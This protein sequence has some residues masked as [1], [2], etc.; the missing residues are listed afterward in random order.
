MESTCLRQTEVP[1]T[2]RLFADL[3]YNFDRVSDLYPHRPNS[4]EAVAQAAAFEFP[5]ARRAA[6]VSALAPLNPGNPSLDLLARPGT[7]AIITG[8]QVG[9]FSGPVYTIYKALTAIQTARQLSELGTPAV[10]VFWMA[11]EDHDFAEVNHVHVFGAD[12]QPVTLRV[13]ARLPGNDSTGTRPVGGIVPGDMPIAELRAALHGLPF[14]DETVALVER[15]CQGELTM[16]SAFARL[17][18]EIFRPFHLLFV[19]PM[20]PALREIAAPLMREAVERMPELADS[21]IARSKQLVDRGYH[22]QVLVDAQTSLAF[23]LENGHRYALRRT[24]G[25]FTAGSHKF[26]A[27]DLAA[28]AHQLSPNALLRPVLQDYMFPTAAYV[29]GPAELAYF[30]QSEV[31]YRNLLGRQPVAMPRAGF[32]I[33]DEKSAKHMRRYGLAAA[34]VFADERT[35]GDAIGRRLVPQQLKRSLENTQSA[36]TVAL[37]ALEADLAKLDP[38]LVAALANSRKKIEY[39]AGRLVAKTT[40]R[41]YERD[42]QAARHARQLSG[43]VFPAKHLQERYYSVLPFLAQFGMGFIDDVCAATQIGCPDHQF[44]TL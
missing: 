12:R 36:F 14:A 8:Q 39:Q 34:D 17:L 22:A 11:T 16:G 3:V 41:I 32:T 43:F 25:N 24:G 20:T 15:S 30:A 23:L 44:L 29:G 9:L 13:A 4:L 26:S 42:E 27:A 40:R 19:D 33:L 7:V 37:N 18:S 2:S 10:P 5:D 21:L 6:L 28:R 38:S 1:G 35:L 31:L